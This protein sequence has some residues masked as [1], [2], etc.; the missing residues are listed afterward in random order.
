MQRFDQTYNLTHNFSDEESVHGQVVLAFKHGGKM[1]VR[2]SVLYAHHMKDWSM[3]KA[4][5][6]LEDPDYLAAHPIVEFIHGGSRYT[7]RWFAGV[8]YHFSDPWP[9][10]SRFADDA[11]FERAMAIVRPRSFSWLGYPDAHLAEH[12]EC[13]D[14]IDFTCY[15]KAFLP[16]TD[17]LHPDHRALARFCLDRIRLQGAEC[18]AYLYEVQAPFRCPTHFIDITD[19][20]DRKRELIACYENTLSQYPQDEVTLALNKFRSCQ[21]E[22]PERWCECF[23]HVDLEGA[24]IPPTTPGAKMDVSEW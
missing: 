5:V 2:T 4:I 13:V 16:W 11:E 18:E 9:E 12:P 8:N 14:A 3:F 24:V 7:A 15:T 1:G 10:R 19:E 20:V 21:R 17:S 6:S 22:E 23:L